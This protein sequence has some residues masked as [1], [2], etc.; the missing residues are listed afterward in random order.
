[1]MPCVA[2]GVVRGSRQ[3][4]GGQRHLP[5]RLPLKLRA[6]TCGALGL[7]NGAAQCDRLGILRIRPQPDKD[8][9]GDERGGGEADEGWY[10]EHHLACWA[11]QSCRNTIRACC[12]SPV[13]SAD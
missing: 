6:M 3:A 12:S 13:T 11:S 8:P 9:G 7:V 1:M 2:G 5:V 10:P 4:P